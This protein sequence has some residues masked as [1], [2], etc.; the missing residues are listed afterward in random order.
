MTSPGPVGVVVVVGGKLAVR[1]SDGLQRALGVIR[2]RCRI[3]QAV[4]GSEH[5]VLG[6]MCVSG[7]W[8]AVIGHRVSVVIHPIP[9]AGSSALANARLGVTPWSHMSTRSSCRADP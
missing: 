4:H 8:T 5:V 9:R 3:S 6:I 1:V 2:A 7:R